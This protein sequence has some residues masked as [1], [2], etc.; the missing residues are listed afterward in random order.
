MVILTAVRGL[1]NL[2]DGSVQRGRPK[3]RRRHRERCNWVLHSSGPEIRLNGPNGTAIFPHR[4]R[5]LLYSVAGA[6]LSATDHMFQQIPSA[7]HWVFFQTL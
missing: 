3:K 5:W 7:T 1:A 6:G 4:F 2:R